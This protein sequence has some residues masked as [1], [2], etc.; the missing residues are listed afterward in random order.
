MS[1][2]G[3]EEVLV[4]G[5]LTLSDKITEN[6]PLMGF[7]EIKERAEEYFFLRYQSV[8]QSDSNTTDKRIIYIDR[9]NLGYMQITAQ[10]SSKQTLIPVWDFFGWE[11]IVNAETI[12]QVTINGQTS[13]LTINAI[14]GSIIDRSLGY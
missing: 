7:D 13:Y 10:N 6:A 8:N 2:N 4:N 14:D 1:N 11:E 9:I 5:N 3:I 12:N